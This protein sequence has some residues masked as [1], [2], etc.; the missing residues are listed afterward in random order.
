ML[1]T[2][3]PRAGQ[4]ATVARFRTEDVWNITRKKKAANERVLYF[5]T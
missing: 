4:K 2:A 1:I 5:E 3:R